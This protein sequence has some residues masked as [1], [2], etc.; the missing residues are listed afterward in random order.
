MRAK[1]LLAATA[2]LSL[3]ALV[4]TQQQTIDLSLTAAPGS[5][6]DID[7]E[8]VHGDIEILGT[9]GD[10]VQIEGTVSAREWRDD[11]EV[12]VDQSGDVIHVY[13]DYLEGRRRND[14]RRMSAQLTV[15]VPHET[16]VELN[17]AMHTTV[18]DLR[19]RLEVFTG[20][21]PM[22]ISGVTGQVD[23]VVANGNLRI[24]DSDL[25]GELSNTNGSLTFRNGSF[26]GSLGSTNGGAELDSI[27]GDLEVDATN[28]T[29]RMGDV[30]GSLRGDLTNGSI[31]AGTVA[32][33]IR[34]ETIN[35]SVSATITGADDV[36]IE[37][38]N[39]TVELEA[40]A[41]LSARF[42][43]EVRQSEPERNRKR[44][45]IRSD[46][47][48]DMTPGEI[49][50]G[51]YQRSASGTAGAGAQSITVHTTNGDVV[52]RNAGS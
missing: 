32:G 28:G 50:G 13:S 14:D 49:R 24:E 48:L 23:L 11:N 7:L 29:V 27:S 34:I 3:L 31:S 42:D 36:D 22:E 46:F 43:L 25:E 18:R 38:L 15:R 26:A 39:G 47:P 6:V 12:I 52:I 30:A 21:N 41:S 35:G 5:T 33:G 51:R 8:S 16:N 17:S 9:D 1:T 2:L 20:N 4:P 37:T 19:G 10:R 44:P 40:P 45:E